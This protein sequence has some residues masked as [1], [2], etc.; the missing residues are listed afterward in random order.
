MWRRNLRNARSRS[1]GSPC[2]DGATIES[3]ERAGESAHE[4]HAAL[5]ERLRLAAAERDHAVGRVQIDPEER[6]GR[7]L[8]RSI[9]RRQRIEADAV[10]V[11]Q[12]IDGRRAHA[13]LLGEV[14]GARS[15]SAR[16][17]AT[18]GG[19]DDRAD[20][21]CGHRAAPAP[22]R[23]DLRERED[24]LSREAPAPQDDGGAAHG[25]LASDRAVRAT[26]RGLANDAA[27]AD[28]RL[29]GVGRGEP[30]LEN[31]HLLRV[32]ANR[33]SSP[34]RSHPRRLHGERIVRLFLRSPT[35]SYNA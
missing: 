3:I 16:G 5:K 29:K 30:G 12:A 13:G 8:L 26:S 2:S 21:P 23:T 31:P 7:A 4:R 28:H 24:P 15:S 17:A 22:P 6:T 20:G 27:A 33:R 14:A 25:E 34:P 32:E 18:S 10:R 11:P 1:R 19:L 35:A 9:R